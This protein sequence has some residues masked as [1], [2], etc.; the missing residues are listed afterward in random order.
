LEV[1]VQKSLAG[2]ILVEAVMPVLVDGLV[3][4]VVDASLLGA[5]R[6]NQ[7]QGSF[8]TVSSMP[9]FALMRAKTVTLLPAIRVILS[10]RL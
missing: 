1:P 4:V 2:P 8:L 5:G 6:T 10:Q 7:W 9:G 3:Q